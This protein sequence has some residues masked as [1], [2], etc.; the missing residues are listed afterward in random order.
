VLVFRAAGARWAIE[1]GYVRQ[2]ERLGPVTPVPGAPDSILGATN[3]KGQ[4]VPVVHLGATPAS[5]KPA[6]AILVDVDGVRAALAAD[7]IDEV[8]SLEAVADDARVLL[9]AHGAR[10]P[11]LDPAQ[12]FAE[13]RARVEGAAAELTARV[14]GPGA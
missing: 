4:I 7:R 3:L 1:L 11:L 14:W 2:V 5:R 10:V 13:L 9:D 6:Q 8:T 12:V